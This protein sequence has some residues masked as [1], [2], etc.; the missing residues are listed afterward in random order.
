MPDEHSYET[1]Y[2]FA[3]DVTLDPD[4]KDV[5][6]PKR[7]WLKMTKKGQVIRCAFIYFYTYDSN[8]V[9]N[10][11]K[12]ARKNGK[13]LT[14]E[15]VAGIVKK[16]LSKRAEDLNKSIDKL[17]AVDKLDVSVARFKAFKAHYQEGLGYV[18]SRIGKDGAE[19]DAIWKRLPEP[20]TVFSTLLLIYP[21]D[22]EGSLNK[23]ALA[24]Q[25]KENKLEL[26]PW[27]FS[28]RV[29]DD[30]W[31]LNDGLRENNLSLASQ[32]IKLECKEPQYQNISVSFAG[33]A[34]WQKNES[35]KNSVLSHAVNM[36]D[37][38]I[39]FRELTTEQLRAKLG[40]G[41]SAVED[42]SSDSFQDMLDQV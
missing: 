34:L 22:S 10:A 3:E 39:P 37:K 25:I 21:T 19:S 12:V 23:E 4:E 6:G 9:R 30:I 29:Y 40:L 11:V 14:Q 32:D 41:G 26:I 24:R 28:N 42:I 20:K 18:M 17:T 36:Y 15:E 16:V 31:K 2:D 13:K 1:E 5:G 35:F 27:R 8:A 38:L 7:D 33:V